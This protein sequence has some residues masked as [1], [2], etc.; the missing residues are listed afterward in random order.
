[1]ITVYV[2]GLI[3]FYDPVRKC[4]LHNISGGGGDGKI[5]VRSDFFRVKSEFRGEVG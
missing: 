3:L 5:H 1:M 2:L 4:K